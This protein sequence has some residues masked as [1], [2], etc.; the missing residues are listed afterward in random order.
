MIELFAGFTRRNR[1]NCP[2]PISD[3]TSGPAKT[4]G[5][6]LLT[7][8]FLAL[9]FSQITIL[10]FFAVHAQGFVVDQS[11]TAQLR[12]YQS[13]LSFTP[14]GQEFTPTVA[15]MNVVEIQILMSRVGIP[16]R[17]FSLIGNLFAS[18]RDGSVSGR[19]LGTSSLTPVDSQSSGL[20]R[21]QFPGVIELTPGRT[22]VM[23]IG[24]DL[25]A[26]SGLNPLVGSS[27][28]PAS[29]YREDEIT[30]TTYGFVK[31]WL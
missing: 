20:I 9:A 15:A 29:V 31:A 28:G 8:T 22:Y 13:V 7:R 19:V 10:E 6:R 16:G 1:G 27:G 2:L 21:M 26:D 14:M 5:F 11:N 3:P 18:I 25:A 30:I 24:A 23:L 17:D 4:T 12:L